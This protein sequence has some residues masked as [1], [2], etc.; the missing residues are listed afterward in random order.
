MIEVSGRSNRENVL[1]QDYRPKPLWV[2]W[3]LMTSGVKINFRVKT[4]TGL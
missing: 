1:A 2:S 4:L 3:M